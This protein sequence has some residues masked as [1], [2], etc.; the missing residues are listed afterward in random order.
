MTHGGFGKSKPLFCYEH[1][2]HYNE[3]GIVFFM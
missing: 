3:M 1:I 2:E